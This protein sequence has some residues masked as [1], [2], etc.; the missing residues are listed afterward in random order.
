MSVPAMAHEVFVASAV[1][2]TSASQPSL[3]DGNNNLVDTPDATGLLVP[4]QSPSGSVTGQ[5]ATYN[6]TNTVTS[7][8]RYVAAMVAA[9][10]DATAFTFTTSVTPGTAPLGSC[11]GLK[12]DVQTAPSAPSGTFAQV[13]TAAI[14]NVA[15][16][17]LAGV[18]SSQFQFYKFQ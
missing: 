4:P 9:A 12:E 17:V 1:P 3:M 14:S 15:S 5:A 10:E 13:G 8:K 2:N 16:V 7:T 6:Y 18:A 11:V